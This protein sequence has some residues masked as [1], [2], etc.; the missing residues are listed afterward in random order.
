MLTNSQLWGLEEQYKHPRGIIIFPKTADY[1][2]LRYLISLGFQCVVEDPSYFGA[3]SWVFLPSVN[4]LEEYK[5]RTLLP[6]SEST[7]ERIIRTLL[8]KQIITIENY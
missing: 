6:L 2:I 3:W 8:L 1:N 7:K 4:M 5:N